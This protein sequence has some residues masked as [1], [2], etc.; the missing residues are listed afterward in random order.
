MSQ[1]MPSVTLRVAMLEKMNQAKFVSLCK[2]K[3]H[4]W[5]FLSLK[6]KASKSKELLIKALESKR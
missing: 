5:F 6:Q 2:L 4:D 1:N 3:A